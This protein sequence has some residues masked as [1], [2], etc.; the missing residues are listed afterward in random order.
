MVSFSGKVVIIWLCIP[1]VS[2]LILDLLGGVEVCVGR[3][4]HNVRVSTRFQ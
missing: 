2:G 1:E 4:E 3:L